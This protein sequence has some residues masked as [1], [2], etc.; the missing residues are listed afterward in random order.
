LIIGSVTLTLEALNL[1]T[2]YDPANGEII[3]TE[4]VNEWYFN[5]DPTSDLSDLDFV[6]NSTSTGPEADIN[7][8]INSFKADGDGWYDIIFYFPEKNSHRFTDDEKVIY[9]ITAPGLTAGSFDYLSAQLTNGSNS[10]P[11]PTASHIGGIDDDDSGWV[12]AKVPEPSVLLLLG[13]SIIGL[14]VIKRRS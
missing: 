2:L 1:T 3:Y 6:Y 5:Y 9:E 7:T 10:G 11:F 14:A 12:T 8:G 13:L 4:W